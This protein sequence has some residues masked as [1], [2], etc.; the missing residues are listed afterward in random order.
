MPIIEGK[1]MKKGTIKNHISL[2]LSKINRKC[3]FLFQ[4]LNLN[5]S[6]RWRRVRQPR[7]QGPAVNVMKLFVTIGCVSFGQ[8]PFG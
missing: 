8:K 1:E 6:K 3:S 5:F 7:R 4:F 2:H